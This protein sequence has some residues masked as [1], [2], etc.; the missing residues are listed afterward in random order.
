MLSNLQGLCVTAVSF[1]LRNMQERWG[2][3]SP[4]ETSKTEGFFVE[5]SFTRRYVSCH[6]CKCLLGV[7]SL[8]AAGLTELFLWLNRDIFGSS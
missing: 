2:K 6:K 8:L 3:H 1:W 4:Q 7:G 5:E